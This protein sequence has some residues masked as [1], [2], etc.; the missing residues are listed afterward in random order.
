MYINRWADSYFSH[1]F[2]STMLCVCNFTCLYM[3]VHIYLYHADKV[4]SHYWDMV[5]VPWITSCAGNE[6]CLCPADTDTSS[7]SVHA[8]ASSWGLA[9]DALTLLAGRVNYYCANIAPEYE[10]EVKLG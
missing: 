7:S 1:Y 8:T 3:F 5:I 9:G 10:D 2:A 6:A 4:G